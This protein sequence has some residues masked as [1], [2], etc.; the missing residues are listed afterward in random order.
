MLDELSVRCSFAVWAS[1]RF[2][3]P[4]ICG[5]S[6]LPG[7][8]RPRKS[9]AKVSLGEVGL[10]AGA[11]S[12]TRF[13]YKPGLSMAPHQHIG[14]TSI[15]TIVKGEL[16]ERRGNVVNV[17]KAGDVITVAE[18]ASHANENAGT[19]DLVYVE[20]NITGTKPGPPPARRKRNELGDA[21]CCIVRSRVRS[22]CGPGFDCVRTGRVHEHDRSHPPG[23]P[24]SGQGR[25]LV[26]EAFRRTENSEGPERLMFGDTRIIFQRNATAKPSMGSA[27]DH[28]GFS[29]PDL[30]ATMKGL[31]ADGAKISAPARDVPGLFKLAFVEDPWGVRIEVVQDAARLG[32]HHI[33]LRAPDPGVVLKWYADTFG[34]TIGKLKDRID[35]ISYGGIWVLAQKGETEPTAGHAIDHLGFRPVNVDAAVAALKAKNVR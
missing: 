26:C 34:G 23:R 4:T 13:L 16:T 18:G 25:G 27:V 2:W 33:H 8:G 12:A 14:R 5:R 35:G 17:Y 22:C 7:R 32:V 15:I 10:P 24:R 6:S 31:E 29:V 3:G 30:D 19:E 1:P 11:A 21:N 28:I 20:I 9:V